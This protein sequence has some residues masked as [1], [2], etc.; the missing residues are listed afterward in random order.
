MAKKYLYDM[1]H[2]RAGDKGD[3]LNL[4]LVPY[5]EADYDL[6]AQLVTS[7]LV[8]T[9]FAGIVEGEVIRYDL[10][11]I[12]SFNFVLEKALAGGVTKSLALDRHGKSLSYHL[13]N[14]QLEVPDD[15]KGGH[16]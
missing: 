2:S 15:F 1:A 13:L 16:E 6:L 7:E 14:M 5:D 8:K 9:H 3:T 4:S 12:S 11:N 10:P